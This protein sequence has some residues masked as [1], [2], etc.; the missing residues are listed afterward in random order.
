MIG[1]GAQ[2]KVY[3]TIQR[4][5]NGNPVKFVALKEL[6]IPI[7]VKSIQDPFLKDKGRR[8]I[9]ILR[10]V[11]DNKETKDT[12]IGLIES[13]IPENDNKLLIFMTYAN[14]YSLQKLLDILERE[15]TELETYHII[16]KLVKGLV[17][18]KKDGII[19][20]DLNQ[21]NVLLH[22]PKFKNVL[23]LKEL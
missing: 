9:N 20:R 1:E 5:E 15:M 14:G 3:L 6:L 16:K 19:H 7:E 8:E 23:D 13:Y 10:K 4:D 18:L 11:K 17:G 22:F 12:C 21:N 2:G